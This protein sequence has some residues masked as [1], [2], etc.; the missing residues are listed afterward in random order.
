MEKSF[1]PPPDE[2]ARRH[3]VKI[4]GSI[5]LYNGDK[6]KTCLGDTVNL[7]LSGALIET[8]H[9]MPVGTLF[10]Y[11]FRIPEVK[12]PIDIAAEVVRKAGPDEKPNAG[13]PSPGSG[14][15][16]LSLYGIRF[17]D[18]KEKDRSAIEWFLCRQQA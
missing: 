14:R 2:R 13:D 4:L 10:K 1:C 8:G 12:D 11:S 17:L 15:K 3:R 16:N 7:S 18:M 9:S 5:V 6:E